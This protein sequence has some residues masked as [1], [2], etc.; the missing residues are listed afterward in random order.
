LGPLTKAVSSLPCELWPP[1]DSQ[2]PQFSTSLCIHVH[3]C[4]I[5]YIHVFSVLHILQQLHRPSMCDA[6]KW[7]HTVQ[8]V[9][10]LLSF[11]EDQM[12]V[13][14]CVEAHTGISMCI[15]MYFPPGAAHFFCESAPSQ[16]ALLCC[17]ALFDASQL[18]KHV[19]QV[20]YM[21]VHGWGSHSIY[22]VLLLLT[23]IHVHVHSLYR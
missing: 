19:V 18:H 8:L 23:N 9:P 2:S 3:V 6:M 10:T 21:Y 5:M 1:G 12:Y 14:V 11:Q 15:Y 20:I 13:H 4:A 17:L 22:V 7:K 16:L